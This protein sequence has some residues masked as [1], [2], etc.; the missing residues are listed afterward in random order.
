V[1]KNNGEGKGDSYGWVDVKAQEEDDSEWV[2]Q[3]ETTWKMVRTALIQDG[4]EQAYT[5]RINGS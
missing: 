4:I 2:G 5:L 3:L 1:T